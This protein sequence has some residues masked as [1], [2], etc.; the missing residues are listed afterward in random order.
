[1]YHTRLQQH[2]VEGPIDTI[3]TIILYCFERVL[4]FISGI[5]NARHITLAENSPRPAMALKSQA[6]M[7]PRKDNMI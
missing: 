4:S 6:Q 2:L 7:S 5:G 3:S 1:M